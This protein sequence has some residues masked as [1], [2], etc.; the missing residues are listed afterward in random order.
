MT[1]SQPQSTDKGG[2]KVAKPRPDVYTVLLG[3]ALGA[4][5]LA[6]IC[7]AM[8]LS[9]YNWDYKATTVRVSQAPA[10]MAP[11]AFAERTH[12]LLT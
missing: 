6:I 2:V 5:L 1:L 7:L 8:E 4:I 3:I 9:R 12:K 10:R 11:Q